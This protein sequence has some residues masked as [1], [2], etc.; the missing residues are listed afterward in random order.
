MKERRNMPIDFVDRTRE[1]LDSS[2]LGRDD[3][4]HHTRLSRD[5]IEKFADCTDDEARHMDASFIARL[6]DWLILTELASARSLFGPDA[7]M[8]FF[9]QSA[10]YLYGQ[11]QDP[12]NGGLITINERA[13]VLKA[14]TKR[15]Q[16]L[17]GWPSGAL[18][19]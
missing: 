19:E 6:H 12:Q 17:S 8:L 13:H 15:M 7:A 18:A 11:R 4:A 16:V 3:I 9:G 1:L 5:W 2:L 14:A 10:A